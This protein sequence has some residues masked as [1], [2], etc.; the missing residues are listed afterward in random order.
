MGSE[1]EEPSRCSTPG[2]GCQRTTPPPHLGPDH[3]HR[4]RCQ[5]EATFSAALWVEMQ[6]IWSRSARLNPRHWREEISFQLPAQWTWKK[7]GQHFIKQPSGHFKAASSLSL[8]LENRWLEQKCWD[9]I[10]NYK[11][12]WKTNLEG[13]ANAN[14]NVNYTVL[15]FL[16]YLLAS[17]LSFF[18][19]SIRSFFPYLC[20]VLSQIQDDFFLWFVQKFK[21]KK[22]FQTLATRH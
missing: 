11:W 18:L 1:D 16:F 22:R 5:A 13:G 14:A 19:F 20:E 9:E 15:S 6:W 12:R 17:F 8:F 21:Q 10:L 3:Q 7:D 2:G 4:G